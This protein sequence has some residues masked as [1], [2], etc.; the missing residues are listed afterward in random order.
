MLAWWAFQYDS[1]ELISLETILEVEHIYARNRYENDKS[2]SDVRNLEALG[3]KALLEKRINIRAA[4]YRFADKIK[5]YQGFTN[6]RN[7]QKEGTQN[8][9]LILLSTAD[10]FTEADIV[11]RTE[12]IMSAFVA[13]LKDNDLTK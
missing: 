12:D 3:N 13:F 8:H 1:Q 9:E 2:L 6:S 11:R 7:Q 5:Y 4:D 10:D